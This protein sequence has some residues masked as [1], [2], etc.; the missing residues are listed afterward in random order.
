MP[1]I[2]FALNVGSSAETGAKLQ[3]EAMIDS[4]ETG[5]MPGAVLITEDWC[6]DFEL[7]SDRWIL[8]PVEMVCGVLTVPAV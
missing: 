5:V 2:V 7:V 4:D 1:G 3:D 8:L 6:E